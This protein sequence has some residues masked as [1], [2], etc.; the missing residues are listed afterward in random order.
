MREPLVRRSRLTRYGSRNRLRSVQSLRAPT[1]ALRL[2][3]HAVDLRRIQRTAFAGT[4]NADG[5]NGT[6]DLPRRGRSDGIRA[7]GR[8]VQLHDPGH[9][10]AV[11][12][13][14]RA[15]Q[16]G[17]KFSILPYARR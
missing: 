3:G 11:Q 17:R 9:L 8:A 6:G 15:F 7:F 12:Y 16:A 2:R 10:Q 14:W 13:D 5:C 1:A 4:A